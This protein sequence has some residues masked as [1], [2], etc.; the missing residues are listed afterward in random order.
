MHHSTKLF[1]PMKPCCTIVFRTSTLPPLK[2]EPK[3]LPRSSPTCAATSMPTS[4]HSVA[5][6]TGKPKDVVRAS[7]FLGPTPSCDGTSTKTTETMLDLFSLCVRWFT[8]PQLW[9]Q[10]CILIRGQCCCCCSPGELSLLQPG[11]DLGTLSCRIRVHPAENPQWPLTKN[12]NYS[13]KKAGKAEAKQHTKSYMYRQGIYFCIAGTK[14]SD[15]FGLPRQR[16]WLCPAW[17]R[18]PQ[19]RPQCPLMSVR[20]LWSQGAASCPLGRSS[21]FRSPEY[22]KKTLSNTISVF[23]INK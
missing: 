8:T 14:C 3:A 1:L 4:S 15:C 20:W 13:L 10:T 16:W 23:K 18:L 2:R 11:R 6:P 22:A 7:S 21:A 5:T 19:P 12:L 9:V 17:G